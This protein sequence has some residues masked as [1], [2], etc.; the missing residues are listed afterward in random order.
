MKQIKIMQKVNLF[1]VLIVLL[2]SIEINANKAND[3]KLFTDEIETF[4]K[5]QMEEGDIQGM[6]VVF[7]KNGQ[8]TIRN[9]GYLNKEQKVAVDSKSTFEIAELSKTFCALAIL[10]LEGKGKININ[11]RVSKYL[12]WFATSYNKTVQQVQIKHLLYQ[13]SGFSSE[14]LLFTTQKEEET[15]EQY[16]KR[17]ITTS[18]LN[19]VSIPGEVFSE[20]DINEFVLATIIEQVTKKSYETY[21]ID[22][23][24][25]PLGMHDS[26]FIKSNEDSTDSTGYKK[27]FFGVS[28]YNTEFQSYELPARGVRMS[29][30]DLATWLQLQSGERN[31]PLQKIILQVQQIDL[32]IKSSNPSAGYTYNMG[33]N[34]S[35]T[36]NGLMYQRGENPASSSYLLFH[37]KDNVSVG[38]LANINSGITREIGVSILEKIQE[39]EYQVA[40]IEDNQMTADVYTIISLV[41]AFFL[42]VSIGYVLYTVFNVT[43]KKQRYHAISKKTRSKVII[44][45]LILITMIGGFWLT[46]NIPLESLKMYILRWSPT[47]LV[48][49]LWMVALNIIGLY[50]VYVVATVFPS[51]NEI[52][53]KLPTLIILSLFAGL[54]DSAIVLI[55]TN[56]FHFGIDPIYMIA[57]FVVVMAVYVFTHKIAH[58]RLIWLTNQLIYEKRM[59]LANKVLSS[60]YQR[61]EKMNR[62]R[63]LSTLNDDTF[64]IGGMADMLVM[65]F[66]SSFTILIVLSYLIITAFW[67]T[68]M[69]FAIASVIAF[70]YVTI[71]TKAEEYLENARDT[72]DDYLFKV[73]GLIDGFKE[74]SLQHKKREHYKNDLKEV[75]ESFRDKNAIGAV[76]L[77]NAYIIGNTLIFAVLGFT[78]FIVPV[79]FPETSLTVMLSITMVVLYLITPI[80]QLLS[81]IPQIFQIKISWNRVTEFLEELKGNEE[82]EEELLIEN[83][84]SPIVE[85][86]KISNIEFTYKQKDGEP[87]FSIGPINLELNKGEI[88]FIVGG[89]GSG[90]TTFSRLLTGL[91]EPHSGE[92]M[93]NDN[94]LNSNQLG[95]YYSTVFDDFFMFKKLYDV[96]L[97]GKEEKIEYYLNVL[98]LKG[99]VEIKNGQ[100]STIDLSRG[101]RKRLALLRCYLEDK[102]IYLFD[103][104][105]ADQDPNFRKFFYRELL[106]EMKNQGKIVI[107]ITHDDHYFDVADKI[108]KL[109]M[110]KVDELHYKKE[111][112]LLM[113]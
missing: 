22:A 31:G 24:F 15:R 84:T 42:A 113:D 9:F 51:E 1:Y 82:N 6:S 88:I 4:I 95:E 46:M 85:S 21:I 58:T 20:S 45:G 41:L 49:A 10:D 100:F 8:K 93:V 61:F 107:A 70:I 36:G 17:V 29:G 63:I 37:K 39:K 25:K 3:H 78:C 67:I 74:L 13:N 53:S 90:K 111:E 96:N 98:K 66:I 76:K 97:E 30:A 110:G 55:I 40:L 92:I 57:L 12:P 26:G 38:I 27:G 56:A 86:L 109:D 19:L 102:P 99:K 89:N 87:P 52:K 16:L 75:C 32:D 106:I 65:V 48:P 79:I 14:S 59:I 81:S 7:V 69:I 54:S 104:W 80:S 68:I 108:V 43:R 50:G 103:E 112:P 72:I 11:D 83:V 34:V 28:I 47:S 91:Y 62:G 33:W 77:I 94:K 71:S 73:N 64:K 60:S 23:I 5:E 18:K 35:I 105:A 44:I 101:Q 2:F